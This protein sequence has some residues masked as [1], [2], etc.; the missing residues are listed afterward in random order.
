MMIIVARSRGGFGVLMGSDV[1]GEFDDVEK[2]R[3]LAALLCEQAKA[4]GEVADWV[5]L[6]GAMAP[7]LVRR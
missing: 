1:V 3:A 2:A 4:R 5:D 6:T 7:P